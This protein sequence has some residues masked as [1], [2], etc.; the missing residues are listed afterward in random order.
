MIIKHQTTNALTSWWIK[1]RTIA[2]CSP[3]AIA[4]HTAE[5]ED[6]FPSF[7]RQRDI[8]NMG[9]IEVSAFYQMNSQNTDLNLNNFKRYSFYRT[10]NFSFRE[11]F[12]NTSSHVAH[13]N[14]DKQWKDWTRI[15]TNSFEIGWDVAT[16]YIKKNFNN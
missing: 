2:F 1:W 7:I 9:L 15:Q 10:A 8:I 16:I 4:T 3:T 6:I 12:F 11:M 5:V 13:Y 14:I